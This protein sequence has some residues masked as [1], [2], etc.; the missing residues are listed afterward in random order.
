MDTSRVLPELC[1]RD[2]MLAVA[3]GAI[4]LDSANCAALANPCAADSPAASVRLL[5]TAQVAAF[6]N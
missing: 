3:L 2:D 4:Y 5:F 1:V 6:T